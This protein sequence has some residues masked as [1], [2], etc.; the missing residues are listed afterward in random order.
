MFAESGIP[1]GTVNFVTGSGSEVGRTLI[2]HRDVDGVVFTGSKEVGYSILKNSILDYPRPVIA[3]MGG[4]NPVIVMES[5]DLDKAV[6]GTAR[7]A[8]GYSGQKCSAASRA[9]VHRVVYEDFITRLVDHTSRLTV[10]D[11]SLAETFMGPVI[12]ESGYR[13]FEASAKTAHADGTI[14]FG[15]EVI[16]QDGYENGY[17]VQPTIVDGLPKTHKFFSEELFL[18]FITI[19]PVD[20]LSEAIDLCNHSEFGLTAGIFTQDEDEQTE[21][22]DRMQA[23]VLYA[24]REG[25]ATTGAWPGVQS[26]GGWKGS[27]STGKSAL[28]PYYVQ[29]FMH[30]QNQTVVR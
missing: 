3:E 16:R 6:V 30:E 27:G 4:K 20:S 13:T 11:P 2:E 28:G 12:N 21:F 1:E 17:F 19:A 26:F 25:G 5:A 9:Y 18:P 29:Q 22:F 23:G 14:R 15:G 7:A 24:N 10:G 8:F